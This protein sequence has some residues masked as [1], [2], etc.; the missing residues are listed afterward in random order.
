MSTPRPKKKAIKNEP[1]LYDEKKI[2]KSIVITPSTWARMKVVADDR[3]ISVSEL[4]ERW[5]R[6]LK[7]PSA[8]S[9]PSRTSV[10]E[11]PENFSD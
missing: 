9:H 1:L 10:R 7:V 8:S 2:K 6:H 4:I 11:I 5:G 3:G